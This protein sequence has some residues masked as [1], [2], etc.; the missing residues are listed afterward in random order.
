MVEISILAP[1]PSTLDFAQMAFKNFF[2]LQT[3][4]EWENRFNQKAWDNRSKR[5]SPSQS[6]TKKDQGKQIPAHQGWYTLQTGSVMSAYLKQSSLPQPASEVAHAEV[7]PADKT[8]LDEGTTGQK[9]DPPV[10]DGEDSGDDGD[11]ESS[12]SC[13]ASSMVEQMLDEGLNHGN[14]KFHKDLPPP[15]YGNYTDYSSPH[16]EYCD[17]TVEF[18]K[19][20][21]MAL[22]ESTPSEHSGGP[23]DESCDASCDEPSK[24]IQLILNAEVN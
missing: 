7:E 23:C 20:N 16:N 1:P 8:R 9:G 13:S 5:G 12:R 2:L 4:V 21:A 11:N 10:E 3:G 14:D 19:L 15:Q 24:T 17:D 18:Y 22:L 6:P